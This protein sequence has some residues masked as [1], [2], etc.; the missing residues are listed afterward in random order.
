MKIL[1]AV[2]L[3][4]LAI[5]A[6]Q[7]Q[8]S[9]QQKRP[10]TGFS[11]TASTSFN[12]LP[13]NHPANS[14][15]NSAAALIPTQPRNQ[16][17]TLPGLPYNHP[18]NSAFSSAATLIP[19]Q[20]ASRPATPSFTNYQALQGQP[21]YSNFQPQPRPANFQNNF[22]NPNF[23]PNQPPQPFQ[24]NNFQPRNTVNNNPRNTA[25]RA[26]FNR[27]G[28]ESQP[29]TPFGL[30]KVNKRTCFQT[31]CFQPTAP[32]QAPKSWKI[33]FYIVPTVTGRKGRFIGYEC[34]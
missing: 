8:D 29:G 23:H 24:P 9:H 2:G 4:I 11:S 12:G 25:S 18:A 34:K 32:C 30:E 10:P 26:S 6:L 3:L 20:P 31:P 7:I 21:G 5:S 14:A 28:F 1:F 27:V 19:T 33:I 17:S 15:F 22:N 13:A 16:P